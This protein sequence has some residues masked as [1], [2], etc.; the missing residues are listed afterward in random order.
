M[1]VVY[2]GFDTI[3]ERDVAL[4]LM[5]PH[6]VE[7]EQHAQRLIR[8]AQAVAKI[9]HPN[10]VTIYEIGDADCGKYIS[11]EYAEG[12]SFGD[13]LRDQSPM[14]VER[15]IHLIKQILDG[16][17]CAHEKGIYHRD[18]KPE[19]IFITANDKVKILDFGIAKMSAKKGLTAVGDVLGTVE[20]M[21]PEQ[22][23]GES[24][25]HR[26]DIYATGVLLYQAL[27]R[28]LPFTGETSVAILFKQLNEEPIPPSEYNTSIPSALDK[29]TLKALKKESLE[30]WETAAA[31]AEALADALKPEKQ[32]KGTGSNT[33]H[34]SLAEEQEDTP[35]S[36]EKLHPVF[37]GREREFKKLLRFFAQAQQGNG[38]TAVISGEAGMGKS[39][40]A[41]QLQKYA[42]SNKAIVLYGASLYQEGM[43]AYMPYIDALR[44]FFSKDSHSLPSEERVKIKNLVR[45][46][47]PVLMEFTER[48]ST[49]FDSGTSSD[50]TDDDQNPVNILEGIHLLVSL[51]STM[52]PV[53]LV[54]DDM[55]WADEA[56]LRLFHY[57]SRHIAENRIL[58]V[59]ISRTDKFDLLQ[60]GKP[61]PIVEIYSR[62][63]REDIFQEI[64]LNHFSR[65]HCETL[66]DESFGNSSFTE[67]FYEMIHHETRGN[68]F[69][70]LETL[71]LLIDNN[72]LYLEDGVWR[73]KT[74]IVKFDVPNRVE[75]VFVRQFSELADEEKEI[76]QVASVIGYK[77]DISVLSR[78]LDIKKITL[79][80]TLQR[81]Q[82]DFQ[83]ISSNEDGFQFEHPM[84]RDILY[85]DIPA[86]LRKEYHLIIAEELDRIYGPEF[87][88]IVGEVANHFHLGGNESKALPLL[89]QAG[90]RA[91]K[92]SA[93]RQ[94]SMFFES[95][96][97]LC[98]N[99]NEVPEN[100]GFADLYLKLA[101]CYE[102][103][104]FWEKSLTTYQKLF[105]LSAEQNEARGK[106][107]ALRRIG[108]ILDQQGKWDEALQKYN[109][110]LE[111]LDESPLRNVRSIIFN[112][113]GLIYFQKGDYVLATEFLGRTIDAVDCDE[114]EIDKAHASAN[115]GIIS[116]IQGD[117][118]Q[119]LK[120]YQTALD[121]Y[122]RRGASRQTTRVYHNIGM[123]Y[124]DM[125]QWKPSIEAFEKC[126]ELLDNAENKHLRGLT[127]L[128]MGKAYARQGN[129]VKAQK[130]TE[131]AYKLF[132]RLSDNLSIAEVFNV[133]GYIFAEKKG[134]EKAKNYLTKSIKIN[135]EHNY[136]EGLAESYITMANTLY[137]EGELKESRK[138]FENAGEIYRKLNLDNRASSVDAEIEHKFSKQPKPAITT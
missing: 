74:G 70:V 82:T 113:I 28:L 97:T 132:N 117:Q 98:E 75:D 68:P 104:G 130:L 55:Q 56:S 126:L 92:I 69:F 31:F 73:N 64:N 138:F 10:I 36:K 65:E 76:L 81:F 23:L 71:K 103:S 5:H 88:A 7:N 120:H 87:G 54:I 107:D 114:G 59:G 105:D 128:N 8:E 89:Q 99:R 45:E 119:A 137:L 30:R 24:F 133:F 78:I 13:L 38:C 25:D 109:Q 66:I 58:Q 100:S 42:K 85:Y 63:R 135:E 79:L 2:R 9:T 72:T 50:P 43:D 3:L 49:T 127:F 102:E 18:I 27:T 111:I 11:M 35:T 94:A 134:F 40:L 67:E 16:L 110:C 61:A 4:K 83:I 1:G 86:A 118:Q 125:G 124:S 57:L 52:Q 121:F 90:L 123:A 14:P 106:V 129:L 44:G 116:S 80:K 91:F 15:I 22:M 77:F 131:R 95:L 26:C 96:L 48:F 62:M 41:M 19:N 115:L 46:K 47:I 93:Y 32:D 51:I 21:A 53:V 84:L 33:S 37:V 29:I 6:L 34:W 101:I 136:Q 122:H 60:N 112:N 20:Y 17:S 39:T 108:R 12:I